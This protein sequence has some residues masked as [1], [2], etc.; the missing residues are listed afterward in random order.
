MRHL[1]PSSLP[2]PPF[3]IFPQS[4]A[5]LSRSPTSLHQR[6]L[7]TLRCL[8]SMR[9]Y[10]Q[11]LIFRSHVISPSDHPTPTGTPIGKGFLFNLLGL[12]THRSS[13][14]A[15]VFDYIPS[16]TLS[17]WKQLLKIYPSDS[18]SSPPPSPPLPSFPCVVDTSAEREGV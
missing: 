5:L 11:H 2:S 8:S 13:L 3:I 1:G 4:H 16:V 9:I 12:D 15:A 10:L 7:L 14:S 17:Q 6:R 18:P